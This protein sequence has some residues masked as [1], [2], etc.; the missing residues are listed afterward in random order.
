MPSVQAVIDLG[1]DFHKR[2]FG[3]NESEGPNSAQRFLREHLLPAAETHLHITVILDTARGLGSSFLDESFVRLAERMNWKLR[4]LKAHV[5]IV[6]QRDPTLIEDI[7]DYVREK[8]G[9]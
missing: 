9:E 4:D 6:S 5:S 7:F 3:R 8:R 2:P 1:N